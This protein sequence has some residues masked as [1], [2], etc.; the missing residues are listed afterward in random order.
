MSLSYMLRVSLVRLAIWFMVDVELDKCCIFF[1]ISDNSSRIIYPV[2][3]CSRRYAS[4]F[5]KS[6]FLI[7]YRRISRSYVSR[8]TILLFRFCL[9]LIYKIFLYV[10]LRKLLVLK[11]SLSRAFVLFLKKYY[12]FTN[13]HKNPSETEI[14]FLMGFYI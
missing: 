14:P 12:E 11:Q 7:C 6:L 1:R 10:F 2:N 13:R 8:I 9:M 3:A 4:L 5:W